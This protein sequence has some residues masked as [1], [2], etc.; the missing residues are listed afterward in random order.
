[1]LRRA[2]AGSSPAA[3]QAS[4]IP[5]GH[6]EGY[7]KAFA[8]LYR[9]LAEQIIARSEARTPDPACLLVPGIEAGLRGMQFIQAAVRS[10]TADAHLAPI[11]PAG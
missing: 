10:S 4:R 11:E 8:I 9:D 5:S 6:P 1:M 3:A 7:L 2:G